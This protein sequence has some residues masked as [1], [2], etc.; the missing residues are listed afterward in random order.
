MLKNTQQRY[1]IIA[2][3]FHWIMF[4][5]LT[6]AIIAGNFLAQLPQ[7]P[8]KLE[9][10]GIHKSVGLLLLLLVLLRLLWRLVN[11][12]PNDPSDVTPLQNRLAHGMHGLL[13]I[14]MFAQPIA[15]I[16]MSQAAGL[17]VSFFG[18]VELP[19]LIGQD[20]SIAGFFKAVHGLVWILLVIAVI[21]HAGAALYHHFI[22][23]DDTLKKM[24][25]GVK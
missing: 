9:A 8:E 14:L 16:L 18:M 17:P 11:P 10:A 1:G 23:K 13:Y 22:Q 15:G 24:T 6:V 12:Q 5:M 4:L 3:S 25:F 7:G 19:T 21:G 20:E 2:K